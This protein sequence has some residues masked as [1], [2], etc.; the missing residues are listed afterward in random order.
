MNSTN[1]HAILAQTPYDFNGG[2]ICTSF[3]TLHNIHVLLQHVDRSILNKRRFDTQ[4]PM[5]W[6]VLTLD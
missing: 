1:A 5:K 2:E 4:G 6:Q 3:G